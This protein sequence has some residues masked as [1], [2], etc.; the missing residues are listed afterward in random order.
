MNGDRMKFTT[1]TVRLGLRRVRVTEPNERQYGH[2]GLE[3]AMTLAHARQERTDVYFVR[4][5]TSLGL[6]LFELESPDVRILRPPRLVRDVFRAFVSWRRIRD[7]IDRWRALKSEE[8]QRELVRE[9]TRYV[10]NPSMP[11][12]VRE[13]VRRMRRRLRTSLEQ[14]ARNRRAGPPY[15]ERRLLREPVPVRLHAAADAAAAGQARAHGIPEDARLVCIHSREGGYK[16]GQ[17]IQD[18]KPEVGRDDRSRNAKIET[19]LEAVDYLVQQGYTVVRLGDPTMSPLRHPGV[20]DLATSPARTNLL[21]IW[22]L[23]RCDFVIAGESA[24]VNLICMTNT[25]IVLVNATEPISAYSV[26]APGLFLLK[27]V[28]DRRDGR[29]LTPVDFLSR[30]YHRQLRDTRRYVYVDNTPEEI[31]DV[32]REMVDWIRG[33]WH[34]S[35]E[36]RSYHDVIM[37]ASA[38]LR[39]YSAYVRKWGL[40]EGFL[41]DGRIAQVSVAGGVSQVL[42]DLSSQDEPRTVAQ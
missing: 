24:Y 36:Q 6:G 13:R 33:R 3:M 14:L 21:E 1:T 34:E 28:V 8:I 40:H 32:T 10:M 15:Y 16:R 17:E 7:Q 25:P 23:L 38:R 37:A 18:T 2:L 39:R 29:R 9:A 19:Y 20:I 42:D 12:P 30:D 35:D 41:G 22:C 31:R 26:R 27:T 4:P 5:A 11:A